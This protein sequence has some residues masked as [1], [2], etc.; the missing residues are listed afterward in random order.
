MNEI[1]VNELEKNAINVYYVNG[2]CFR[3]DEKQRKM[4]EK[5]QPSPIYRDFG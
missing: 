2:K 5:K 3:W 1:L 4:I